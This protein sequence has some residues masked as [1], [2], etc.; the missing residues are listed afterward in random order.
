M[1]WH[2]FYPPGLPGHAEYPPLP[3]WEFVQPSDRIAVIHGDEAVSYRELRARI[4]RAAG[5]FRQKGVGP[6][7]RVLL[8]LPNSID[9]IV[10]Y[11]GALRAGGIVSAASPELGTA[12]WEH[13]RKDVGPVLTL[14]APAGSG[15]PQQPERT[16]VAV[17]QYTSGT[18]GAAKG[19]VMTHANL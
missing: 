12:A 18:T 3:L 9:F 4:E 10:A 8:R 15:Q 17:L 13:Q 1:R 2:A 5:W 7:E 6:G 19:A 14:E 11:Y 16:E